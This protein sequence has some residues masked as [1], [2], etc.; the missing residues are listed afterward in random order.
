MVGLIIFGILGT[1][2]ISGINLYAVKDII[3]FKKE[4]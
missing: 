3:K 4:K 1:A 2:I